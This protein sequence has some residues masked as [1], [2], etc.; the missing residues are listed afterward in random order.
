MQCARA[1]ARATLPGDIRGRSPAVPPARLFRSPSSSPRRGFF[2][3]QQNAL[4][5]CGWTRFAAAATR[6]STARTRTYMYRAGRAP[7]GCEQVKRALQL[8][9]SC[10]PVLYTYM[11]NH[12]LCGSFTY[13]SPSRSL[14][15][16]AAHTRAPIYFFSATRAAR[17]TMKYENTRVR[18][19]NCRLCAQNGQSRLS[20]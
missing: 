1:R 14:A 11:M 4:A 20:V 10:S 9:D 8:S 2:L 18:A 12:S 7:D 6:A 3:G 17:C 16:P 15:L 19:C 13:F 5:R